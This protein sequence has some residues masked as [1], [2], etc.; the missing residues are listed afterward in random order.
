MYRIDGSYGEGG[1]QLLRTAVALAAVTGMPVEVFSIRGKRSNPGMSAQHLAAV[2][3]VAALCDAE[4]E[5]LELRSTRLVFRPGR[6]RGGRFR[7]DV[8]TAG[9]LTLVLQAALPAAISCEEPVYLVLTGGTD[10]KA[11]PPL[12]YFRY[13]F[14][15]LLA[16][17]GLSIKVNLIRRGYYPR[18]GGEV[19]VSIKPARPT[20]LTLETPGAVEEVGGVV[21]VA[22]LPGHIAQRM[23]GTATKAFEGFPRVHIEGETL[24]REDAVG[25]G[26]AAVLWARTVHTILGG[27][28]L[29]ERGV[30]AERVAESAAKELHAEITSGATLDVHTADQMLIYLALADGPSTFL[31]RTFS[32]HAQT[33]IWLLEQ[34]LPVRF[35]ISQAGTLVRV[36]V[37]KVKEG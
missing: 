25:Q 26:G 27:S 33:A 36:D 23:L 19:E 18:G 11:A 37:V 20:P 10:V 7:C 6:L 30:P 9:S 14:L 35:E 4:T 1:G 15:P 22:N 3:T 8:G 12:D 24:G 34:F 16:R 29:A 32:S 21:H 31:C 5:G 17:L 28:A 2:R 13:V